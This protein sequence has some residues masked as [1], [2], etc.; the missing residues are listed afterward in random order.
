MIRRF[1]QKNGH[2]RLTFWLCQLL[3]DQPAIEC[4]QRSTRI[5]LKMPRFRDHGRWSIQ[6]V[7]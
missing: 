1:S 5:A 6:P 4:W 3:A 7:G 2:E